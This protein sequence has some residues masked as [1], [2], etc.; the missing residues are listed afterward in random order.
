MTKVSGSN[1]LYSA[2]INGAL[3]NVI[4]NNHGANQTET[5][6]N[7]ADGDAYIVY[8]DNGYNK[9]NLD[10]STFIDKYMKFET[11]WTDD[12]GNGSCKTAGWYSSAKSA[13]NSQTSAQKSKILEHEPTGYR[14][15][16]W[17]EANGEHFNS[18]TGVFSLA[19][20]Q[21]NLYGNNS[22]SA[23]FV[24]LIIV[25]SLVSVTGIGGYFFIR[26]RKSM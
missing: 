12:E 21:I 17:A 23:H 1:N 22:D 14:L 25:I 2:E 24:A 15:A 9:S 26:R 3:T 16:A 19:N 20:P 18:S 7:V 5:I 11:K 13:F 6:T 10:A 4:F 8:P